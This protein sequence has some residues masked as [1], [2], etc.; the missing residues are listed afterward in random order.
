MSRDDMHERG[1]RTGQMVHISTTGVDRKMGSGEWS[2]VPYEI[3]KGCVATYFPE[4]NHLI[5][6]ESYGEGS[7]TPTS[8]SVSV[9]ING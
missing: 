3:P 4:S 2:V 1:F 6:I 7:F 8:K 9:L 5:P